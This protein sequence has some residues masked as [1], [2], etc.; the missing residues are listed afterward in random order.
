MFA[1]AVNP[2]FRH[3]L[4][5]ASAIWKMTYLA[6]ETTF[7]PIYQ[8]RRRTSTG[9]CGLAAV[10]CGNDFW[11]GTLFLRLGRSAGV[12]PRRIL[13]GAAANGRRA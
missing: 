5:N 3:G 6:S 12:Y 13:A 9:K 1:F 2:A 11:H 4:R 8:H 10:G 7:A